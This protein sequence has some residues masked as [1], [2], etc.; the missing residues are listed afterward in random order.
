MIVGM[1][2][3]GAMAN[4]ITS[5]VAKGDICA[6]LKFFYDRN[7]EKAEKLASQV[8]GTVVQDIMTC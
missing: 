2:G 4:I 1:L 6:D 5:C 7:L 8:Y 3:C